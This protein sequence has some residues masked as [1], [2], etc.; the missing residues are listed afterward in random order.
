MERYIGL[1]YFSTCFEMAGK[2]AQDDFTNPL[3]GMYTASEWHWPVIG[4]IDN[5]DKQWEFSKQMTPH[6]CLW[7][8]YI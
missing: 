7:T 6:P 3:K 1:L 8:A 2:I 5:K 4:G